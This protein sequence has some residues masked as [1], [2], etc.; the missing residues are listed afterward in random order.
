MSKRNKR[1]PVVGDLLKHKRRGNVYLVLL[2]SIHS[3][4]K[5]HLYKI[6][7]IETGKQTMI[8]DLILDDDYDI[9]E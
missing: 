4:F 2:C 6:Q 7:D 8:S 3:L 1:L 9:V 5:N